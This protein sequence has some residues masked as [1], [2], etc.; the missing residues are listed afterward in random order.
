MQ[1]SFHEDPVNVAS[2]CADLNQYGI[3]YWHT[4]RPNFEN[5]QNQV[6]AQGI[7]LISLCAKPGGDFLNFMI[8]A[9]LVEDSPK[10]IEERVAR[11]ILQWEA[12]GEPTPHQVPI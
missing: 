4:T 1:V 3:V 7:E 9:D 12:A 6:E 5:I 10:A 11:A 2:L 8:R